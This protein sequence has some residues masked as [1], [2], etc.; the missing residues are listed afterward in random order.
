M[1]EGCSTQ[2]CVYI[3]FAA[4]TLALD[5]LSCTFYFLVYSGKKAGYITS[6]EHAIP[7]TYSSDD[8]Q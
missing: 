1:C 7:I 4:L 8:V 6:T 3:N 2:L 5:D